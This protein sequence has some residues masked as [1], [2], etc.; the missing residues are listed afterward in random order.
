MLVMIKRQ[1]TKQV[2]PIAIAHQ[3]LLSQPQ[4]PPAEQFSMMLYGVEYS[5][6][7]WGS[8]VS[9]CDPS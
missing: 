3:P 5:F 6:V 8:A 2:M 9:S 7:Q 1:Y 4:L